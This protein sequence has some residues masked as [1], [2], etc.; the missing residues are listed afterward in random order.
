M[1]YRYAF[2]GYDKDR[3]ARGVLLSAP[4]STK[5]CIEISS[6]I[7]GKRIAVA[8]K[9]LQDAIE[10]KRAIPFKRFNDNVGHKKVVGPGRYASKACGEV[11]RVVN[12]C[13]A[14]AENKGLSAESLIVK[15]I[16]ANLASRPWHYGRQ[17]RRKMKRTHIEV[18]LEEAESKKKTKENKD[19]PKEDT[20]AKN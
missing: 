11:L 16:S 14:N 7:K 13:A 18:V 20:P 19:G 15:H 17:T 5:H 4:V 9:I 10:L 2:Q 1:A 12:Q 6:R 3:M 8:R